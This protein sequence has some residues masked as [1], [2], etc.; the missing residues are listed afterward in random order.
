MSTMSNLI[1]NL[2]LL[3]FIHSSVAETDDVLDLSANTKDSFK[4]E[5]TKYDA[6]LVEFC[7]YPIKQAP[8]NHLIDPFLI[9]TL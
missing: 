8:S 7:M 3:V 2:I 4:Q 1:K 5:I 9:P 6:I